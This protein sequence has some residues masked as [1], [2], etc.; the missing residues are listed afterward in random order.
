MFCLLLLLL[1]LMMMLRCTKKCYSKVVGPPLFRGNNYLFNIDCGIDDTD[2][3]KANQINNGLDYT[4]HNMGR[5]QRA[6]SNWRW[7]R[8]RT[9]L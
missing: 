6:V 4:L 5:I 8:I 3:E 2:T 9:Q 7:H 1:L